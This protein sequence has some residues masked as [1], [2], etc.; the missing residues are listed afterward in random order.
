MSFKTAYVTLSAAVATS[1]T[2]AVPYPTGTGAGSYLA[3]G[4]HVMTALESV[5]TTPAGFTVSFGASEIT[6][7]YKGS[8]TLPAGARIGFQFDMIGD[9]EYPSD[10]PVDGVARADVLIIDLGVPVANDPNGACESQ[11][12]TASE[13]AA[14]NGVLVSGG[15]AVFDVPR[16]VVAAWTN[17]AVLT[18][19]GTDVYGNTI[20]EAS[21]SGTSL[22]GKKAFK[23]ITSVVPSANVTGLTVGHAKVLGLPCALPATGYV[24]KELEDGAAPT[25]GTL[26]AAVA[27][28]ATATTGDVR[29]TYAPNSNPNG[30]KGFSLIAV[31]IDPDYKGVPQYAG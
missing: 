4:L 29:G 2:I 5:F 31:G 23:T 22:T 1:G 8:T 10:V 17:T 26:A 24:L 15:V 12:V 6:V 21:G 14:L 28:A 20:V 11:S 9:D 27:A 7:T 3:A 13:A 25:A 16:N 30:A 18:V 19:T